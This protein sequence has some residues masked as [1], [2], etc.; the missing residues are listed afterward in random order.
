[1]ARELLSPWRYKQ[2]GIS[3]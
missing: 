2:K 1:M 3:Y